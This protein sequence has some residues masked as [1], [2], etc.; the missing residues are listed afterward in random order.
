MTDDTTTPAPARDDEDVLTD[1]E[2]AALDGVLDAH[3]AVGESDAT[4]WAFA[5]DGPLRAQEALLAALRM[6]GR[7]HLELEDAAIVAKLGGRVRISQTKDVSTGQ[8]ALRTT[9]SDTDP[10]MARLSPPRPRVPMTRTVA[11]TRSAYSHSALPGSPSSTTV[12]TPG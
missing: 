10:S 3:K 12:S 4:L 1:E 2:R 5:L 11:P 9:W 7:K 8:G 6:V